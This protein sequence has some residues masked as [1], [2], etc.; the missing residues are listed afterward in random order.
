MRKTLST[1]PDIEGFLKYASIALLTGMTFIVAGIVLFMLAYPLWY[2]NRIYPSIYI[3][4]VDVG[5]LNKDDAAA[6]ISLEITYTSSGVIIFDSPDLRF[7]A[8][9]SDVGLYLDPQASA[10][11]AYDF[12]RSGNQFQRFGDQLTTIFSLKLLPPSL[13]FDQR[14]ADRLLSQIS[15]Q[16]N[17]PMIESYISI[18][19]V[20]VIEHPGQTGMA[21]NTPAVIQALTNHFNLMQDG[22]I[23]LELIVL[24]PQIKDISQSANLARMILS[25][26]LTISMPDGQS[27]ESGPW[28][29]DTN[30]LAE[31]IRFNREEGNNPGYRVEIDDHNL[32]SYLSGID[33]DV[34]L[35]PKSTRFI[36]NDD[37]RLLEIIEPAVTGRNVNMAGSIQAIQDTLLNGRHTVT[38]ELEYIK[39]TVTDDVAG[40]Q[41]GITELIH[42]ETSF[43]YGSST[44]RVQNIAASAKQFH[45]LLIAPG[46]T[47]SMADALGDISLD[48]GY[49]EALII[50]GGQTIKGIGGGVCQVSTTLF[51]TAFFA[52][53]PIVE[54]HAHA[55]RVYY[56]EKVAGNRIDTNLAGLDAT[57]YV[58]VVDL[59]FTNDSPYWILM[60]TYVNPTYSSIQ[61]KFYSTKDGRT[62]NWKTSGLTNIKKAP[63]ALYRENPEL[64]TGEIKQIDWEADGADVSI[65]REVLHDGNILFSDTFVTNYQPWQ[66]IWE[67]GPGTEGMPPSD[68]KEVEN[69]DE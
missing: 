67:Y 17:Q 26:P 31:S 16:I 12:G 15:Q 42:A 65:Q 5:G 58:P 61:W 7:S 43:F 68:D 4:D 28:N 9:P 3:G 64:E 48:N 11:M 45:G 1:N 63:K 52:G 2:S 33:A 53:F 19:G 29:I 62:V 51:R 34:K 41:L 47:F 38:L 24:E 60:E 13:I 46:E 56:Y 14:V 50:Y 69:E 32:M 37:T 59:K 6:K 30:A 39:P 25:E 57:V 23:P 35:P 49:A 21:V 66:A 22:I 54:R 27:S 10:D 20:E 8:S 44:E 18:E 36:F 40:E 55:Y